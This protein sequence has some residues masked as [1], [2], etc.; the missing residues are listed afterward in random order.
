MLPEVYVKGERSNFSI[1]VHPTKRW[2]AW[3]TV[4]FET[5]N[6]EFNITDRPIF[7]GFPY[8]H[9]NNAKTVSTHDKTV[10]APKNTSP[11]NSGVTT[12]P[13]A[14]PGAIN[15]L[16][17]VA[18]GGPIYTFNT[19]LDSKDKFPPHF[20]NKWIVA[21]FKGGMWAVT[22]DTNAVKPVSGTPL[23]LDNGIFTGAKARN[24]VQSMYGQ[25][26][27]L[28]ILNYDGDYDR[29]FNPG[30]MRVAYTG[31]CK[32]PVSLVGAPLPE[33]Y[34]KVWLSQTG[35][36]VAEMGRHEF[37]LFDLRGNRVFHAAGNEGAEYR[38][39][40][41]KPQGIAAGAALKGVY[42]VKVGTQQGSFVRSITLM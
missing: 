19:S 24:H 15:N 42:M 11:F 29:A 36:R 16:V 27:A 39:K 21:G 35:L 28:Y 30:V 13:P 34:Q 1:A 17:N 31:A 20:H 3:G 41:L 38:F 10:D 40:D 22:L 5:T 9:A 7:T 25:D 8:F 23:R 4:N 2:L 37:S 32:V 33:K 26:G 6:D 12:L 14:V 18:I